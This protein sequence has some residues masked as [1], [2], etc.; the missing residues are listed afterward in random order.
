MQSKR[1][2]NGPRM[3][4]MEL[5]L[6]HPRW[7]VRMSLQLSH[8]LSAAIFEMRKQHFT[9]AHQLMGFLLLLEWTDIA[10]IKTFWQENEDGNSELNDSMSHIVDQLEKSVRNICFK[11]ILNILIIM[12]CQLFAFHFW[13]WL[14]L[15]GVSPN[16][17]TAFVS[18][19]VIWMFVYTDIKAQHCLF[20]CQ[21]TVLYTSVVS[22][23]FTFLLGSCRRWWRQESEIRFQW[24]VY[25]PTLYICHST[26]Q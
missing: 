18:F 25:T 26:Q 21:L 17:L 12:Y 6:H 10:V 9:C 4:A 20:H 16:V 15:T 19:I 3:N 13:D 7:C 22:L 5:H 11:G 8:T 23:F 1:N 14:F 24:C 2:N